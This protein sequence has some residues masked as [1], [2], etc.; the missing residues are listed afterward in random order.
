MQM[1]LS[2][3]SFKFHVGQ[4]FVGCLLLILPGFLDAYVHRAEFALWGAC[5]LSCRVFSMLMCIA[6][7]LRFTA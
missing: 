3:Y 2:T 7:N 5:R 1:G 4:D 6:R